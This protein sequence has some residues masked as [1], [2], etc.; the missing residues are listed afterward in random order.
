MILTQN[1]REQFLKA[2]KLY[3]YYRCIASNWYF[4]VIEKNA[5]TFGSVALIDCKIQSK[6]TTNM[7]S[8]V[9]AVSFLATLYI[10]AAH[11]L[12]L[13]KTYK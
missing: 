3:I 6:Q 12:G 4:K 13:D 9:F 5:Y 11:M 10:S 2:L 8:C 1:S 7:E